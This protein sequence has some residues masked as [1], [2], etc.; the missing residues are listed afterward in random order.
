MLKH[1][2][3]SAQWTDKHTFRVM[4]ILSSAFWY[5]NGK[6]NRQLK[7]PSPVSDLLSLQRNSTISKEFSPSVYGPNEKQSYFCKGQSAT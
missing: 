7:L 5:W 4:T 2:L 3:S 1:M 6:M